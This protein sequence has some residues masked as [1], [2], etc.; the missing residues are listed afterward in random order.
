MLSPHLLYLCKYLSFIQKSSRNPF[1]SAGPRHIIRKSAPLNLVLLPRIMAL[2]KFTYLLTYLAYMY[3]WRINMKAVAVVRWSSGG[4]FWLCTLSF[5]WCSKTLSLLC[6]VDR[7][8]R[9]SEIY[10][11]CNW[12]CVVTFSRLKVSLMGTPNTSL[13]TKHMVAMTTRTTKTNNTKDYR[14]TK[15]TTWAA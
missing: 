9:E 12:W 3:T 6:C 4:C 10:L 5:A 2:Y 7:N 14:H 15:R 8:A 1:I 13:F 11:H